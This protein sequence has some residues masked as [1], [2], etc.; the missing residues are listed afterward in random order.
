[1]IRLQDC[2]VVFSFDPSFEDEMDEAA[3][4]FSRL[5]TPLAKLTALTCPYYGRTVFFAPG[6]T[7]FIP[8]PS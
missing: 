3:L 2:S 6:G 7:A 4:G 8:R 1:M 5:R